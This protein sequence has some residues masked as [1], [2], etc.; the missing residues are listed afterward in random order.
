MAVFMASFKTPGG[1]P[2]P[3]NVI[4]SDGFW[5]R[6]FN[7]VTQVKT[8]V[9]CNATYTII[10]PEDIIRTR[11]CFRPGDVRSF[12]FFFYPHNLIEL[13]SKAYIIYEEV[14]ANATLTEHFDPVNNSL[15]IMIQ[16]AWGKIVGIEVA[17]ADLRRDRRSAVL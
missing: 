8:E 5:R 14:G 9:P 6:E 12:L 16:K 1:A 4:I 2:F 11:F 17:F 15:D 3:V 7:N 13:Y 10:T